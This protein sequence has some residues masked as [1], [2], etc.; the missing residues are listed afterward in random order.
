[1]QD[2]E[3][4]YVFVISKATKDVKKK[5]KKR[6]VVENTFLQAL[7]PPDNHKLWGTRSES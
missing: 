4:V 6:I 1:M 5:K 2:R 7:I 3:L